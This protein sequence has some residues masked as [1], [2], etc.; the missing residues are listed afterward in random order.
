M[1]F[2]LFS[3]EQRVLVDGPVM[4]GPAPSPLRLALQKP[5]RVHL[6]FGRLGSVLERRDQLRL[7]LLCLRRTLCQRRFIELSLCD[8]RGL[9]PLKLT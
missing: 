5:Q 7:F 9:L 8:G 6:C 2:P 1:A 3:L 4:S